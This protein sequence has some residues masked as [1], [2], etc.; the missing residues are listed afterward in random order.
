M[1][2]RWGVLACAVLLCVYFA[3]P[4]LLG[5]GKEKACPQPVSLTES[6]TAASEKAAPYR[7]VWVSYLEWQRVDFGSAA[8]FT[9]AVRAMLRRIAA[10]GGTVVLAQVRPFGD[11]I[12]PSAYYPF[13]HLCT[14]VQGQTPGFDPLGILVEEAHAQGLQLEAWLNPY[15]IRAGGVPAQL[16][17][18]SPAVQYPDWVKAVGEDL[19][20]D[21]AQPAVRQYIADAV[22]ELCEKYPVDGIHF[23][24]YFYPTTD[25]AFDADEYAAAGTA[26]SLG[27]WRRQNVD[28]LVA[29]CYQ[30]AHRFG[31]RFG[32]AP[33]GDPELNYSV[34]YS[35][36]A[37]WLAAGGYVDYLM[38]QLYWGRNYTK[39]GKTSQSL[40]ELAAAWAALPRA[41]GV[42]LYAGLAASR[43]GVGDGGDLP[44]EWTSGHALADQLG[45]LERLGVQGAALYRYDALWNNEEFPAL[46]AAERAELRAVWAR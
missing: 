42:A 3:A 35:D 30:A 40:D 6:G 5:E 15:R 34:Q 1:V 13:S 36:A 31:V 46:A 28:A 4:L 38:P 44:G 10:A 21:P 43:I 11:A 27:D 45:M 24:D 41:E 14:G 32:V 7:A 23:D 9:A 29:L 12:Y 8:S 39:N 2:R 19:Y 26:L 22:S 20:F 17:A 16:C 18:L 37:R 25:P 33:L